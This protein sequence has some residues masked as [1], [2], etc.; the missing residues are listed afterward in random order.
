MIFSERSSLKKML[1]RFDDWF[2]PMSEMDRLV[3]KCVDPV[4]V[5]SFASQMRR[6]PL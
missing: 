6:L 1:R 2:W 3:A 5:K 4:G